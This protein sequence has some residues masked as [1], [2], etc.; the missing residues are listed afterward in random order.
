M[1]KAF[2]NALCLDGAPLFSGVRDPKRNFPGVIL[3]RIHIKVLSPHHQLVALLPS[4]RWVLWTPSTPTTSPQTTYS[5]IFIAPT[6]PATLSSHPTLPSIH[7]TPHPRFGL[8]DLQYQCQTSQR[9][10]VVLVVLR[11][12]GESTNFTVLTMAPHEVAD[13][14]APSSEPPSNDP[15]NTTT[16]TTPPI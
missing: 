8:P 11:R 12:S 2:A 3:P 10:H 4:F 5:T 15:T 1:I 13:S 14:K 9:R 16:R 7:I 6:S